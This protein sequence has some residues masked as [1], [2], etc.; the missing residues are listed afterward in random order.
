MAQKPTQEW[1]ESFR[2]A[3]NRDQ[4]M[5]VIGHW[6]SVDFKLSFEG[7]DYLLR[8]RNGKIDEIVTAPRFDLPAEFSLR[9]PLSVWTK[10]I[11]PA[12]PPLYHDFFAMLMRVPEFQL[13][14]NS[15]AAMQNARALHRLMSILQTMEP[16]NAHP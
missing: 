4:E 2:Q 10:F 15:L 9:A 6:F 5:Q 12:P 16:L 8:V 3:V 13:D 14:G 1:L 11:N 7:H